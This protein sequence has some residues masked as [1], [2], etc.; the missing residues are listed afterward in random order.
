MMSGKEERQRLM[1]KKS[2]KKANQPQLMAVPRLM[3]Q[4]FFSI[5]LCLSS[6]PDIITSEVTPA[7]SSLIGH[8]ALESAQ[9]RMQ[10]LPLVR[11]GQ[12]DGLLSHLQDCLVKLCH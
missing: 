2:W 9:G 5:N 1:E 10:I 7:S 6:F 4:L 11:A 3:F 8:Q 12:R